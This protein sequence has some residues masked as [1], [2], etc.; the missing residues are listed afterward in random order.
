MGHV[1]VALVVLLREKKLHSRLH[2]CLRHRRQ[3]K[4]Q[5][6]RQQRQEGL[7]ILSLIIDWETRG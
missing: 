6:Q 4:S 7:L 5:Q 3:R 1:F 2:Y